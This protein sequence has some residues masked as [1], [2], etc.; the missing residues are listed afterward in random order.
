MV[1]NLIQSKTQNIP[2]L[3]FPGF[4]GVWE[5]KKFNDLYNFGVTNSF[6]RD[7]LNY[8][9]GDVYN[10][11]YGDIHTKFKSHFQ[12]KKEKVPFVNNFNVEGVSNDVFVK[13]GD[14]IVA[15]TS[16]DYGDIGKTIE[17]ISLN[18]QKVVSGL[19]TILGK[20]KSDNIASGFMGHLM[21]NELLR[22]RIKKI[23]Q[24]VKVLGLPK[25]YFKNLKI[26][27]P[28]LPE[29][30]KISNFFSSVDEWT[31]NLKEQKENL[32]AYKKGMMQK[33]FSQEVRFKGFDKDW[34][35]KR[36]GEVCTVQNGYAFKSENF[37]QKQGLLVIRISN[38]SSKSG[39]IEKNN[40]VYHP[41]IDI[42]K[43]FKVK[44]GD[45][46]IAMSGATTGKVS[47]FDL[48]ELAYVNQR[49]G[50]FKLKSKELFYDFLVQM[51]FS[52]IFPKQLRRL[53]VA[54]AQ[55]NICSSDIESFQIPLPC[56]EEQ[57]KIANFLTS[58]DNLIESKQHQIN[59]AEGWKKGL[60]RGLFV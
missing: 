58:L 53:L 60:I 19:H 11:H 18:N 27:L 14:I 29:Q 46:L 52:E 15:D 59:K 36:L 21:K 54:G 9:I 37:K 35:E 23:A 26:N 40:S 8:K 56:F 38:I 22:L 30:Q 48:D 5:E 13:E 28:T 12:I 39:K 44:T 20:K 6:S 3:R 41:E 55:P 57:Q 42:N 4:S 16:E 51:A 7:K 2:K 43:N 50:I 31:Q 49:V 10:I 47:V 25:K 17:I 34:E 1:S 45:L 24:G 33:I 32:E